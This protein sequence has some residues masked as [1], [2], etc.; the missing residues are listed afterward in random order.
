MLLN[1]GV[2]DDSWESLVLDSKI[3]PVNPKRNQPWIFIGRTDAE[4][5]V[6]VL[7]LPDVKSWC[8]GKDPDT[9]KDWG[10]EEKGPTEDE[11]IGWHT[12]SMAWIW[13]NSGRYWRESWC[14]A[15]HGVAKSR[16]R[17]SDWTTTNNLFRPQTVLHKTIV[18]KQ[19]CIGTKTNT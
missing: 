18:I 9:G 16:T 14:A 1:G 5:E 17:L 4:A 8:T 2:E 13:A 10:Q 11:M 15:D 6:P 19:H 7:Q 12:D 3:K